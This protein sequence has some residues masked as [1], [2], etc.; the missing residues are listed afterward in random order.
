MSESPPSPSSRRHDLDALRAAAMLLGI[1]LHSALSFGILPWIVQ[2]SRQHEAFGW[3]VAA[4][5]GFRMPVFF[6]MSGF[7]TAMLWRRRGLGSLVWQRSRRVLLP[8]LIGLFT[9]VPLVDWVCGEAIESAFE[10]DEEASSSEEKYDNIWAAAAMGDI[11]LMMEHVAKGADVNGQD[12]LFGVTPLSWAALYGRTEAAGFLIV[13]GAD[14]DCRN[15]DG[16]TA[17]HAAACLGRAGTVNFLLQQGAEVDARNSKGETPLQNTQVD[18]GITR[19]IAGLLKIE[20]DQEKVESG[21][22]ECAALLERY[23]AVDPED[24]APDQAAGGPSGDGVEVSRDPIRD[25]ILR[26]TFDPDFATPVFHH[27]WFLWHLCWLVAAFTIYAAIMNRLRGASLPRWLTLPGI[28]FLWL[29]PLTMV[30]QWYMGLFMPGF[31]PDTSLGWLPLPH[32]L[33]YYALF[34]GFGVLYYD[35]DDAAGRVGRWWWLLIPFALLVVF[36]LGYELSTGEF[37]FRDSLIEPA[38][39]R[40]LAVAL[41][42][43]YAWMM[44]FGLMGLFRRL[45][46]GES[47][48]IRYLSDSSYWL[49]LAH[50]PLVIWAQMLVRDWQMSAVVKCSLICVAASAFLLVLYQV[51]VRYTLIGRMLN[52][53]RRR[54]G[55]AAASV[56]EERIAS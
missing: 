9:I 50:V 21:R 49:Y 47:R 48:I 26:L 53:P 36:P 23:G 42:A 30:P 24:A 7:F 13:Q 3:F 16:A 39:H 8:C 28:R 14:L 20:V 46:T 17:L 33:L 52:G 29:I 51:F 12:P 54:R 4:V 38:A 41:Q 35:S 11:A 55:P 18:W 45:L 27:L 43:A 10:K 1:A 2:D 22:I 15:R 44:T 25:W 31:G 19:F 56:D 5:H 37:G 32:V 34:F 40:L 6:V